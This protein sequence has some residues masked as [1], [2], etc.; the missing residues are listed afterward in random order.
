MLMIIKL[1]IVVVFF[2]KGDDVVMVKSRRVGAM[3]LNVFINRNNVRDDACWIYCME[4]CL[5]VWKITVSLNYFFDL[6]N[7]PTKISAKKI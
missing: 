2:L 1:D 7:L 5:F 4:N 3:C 6:D